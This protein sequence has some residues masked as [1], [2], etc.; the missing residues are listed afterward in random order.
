MRTDGARM[1]VL[2]LVSLP[3]LGAGNRLRVEQYVPLL[4]DLGIEMDVAPFFDDAAYAVLYA[5]GTLLFKLA[6][7]IRGLARRLDHVLRLRQYDLVLVY[8][9]SLPLGPPLIEALLGALG[10]RYVFDFDDA[11]FL[12]PVH[13]ANRSW[14][15]LR[16]PSR[17]VFSVRR[18]AAVV[19]GN[20]YLAAWARRW[21]PRVSVIPTPVDTERHVPRVRPR[22]DGP[23]VIGWVGSSTTAPY[24]HLLDEPLRMLATRCEFLVRVIG[25]EYSHPDLRVE[26]RP[27]RLVTE[28]EEV[29][30]FDIGVLP[31]PDDDWTRG[32]G[33]F[34]A[35]LYMAAEVP[36]V[37][38]RV[39]VAAE[40]VRDGE[41]GFC[42]DDLIGWAS[43]L[44]RL[45]RDPALRRD[46]GKEGR[47]RVEAHYSLR[48]QAPRLADVLR[49]A[50]HDR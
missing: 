23:I 17:V 8:R 31:Q 22:A 7:V 3:T 47:H 37:A 49:S 1:R 12:R 48:V 27:Y 24:L 42:V 19:A 44:E 33:A 36:V 16:D 15:W 14:S 32:K 25:G 50:A 41:T 45:A 20:E 28:P 11:I 46:L 2:A 21:N 35:L 5:P 6:G 30:D 43:T 26:V 9:E 39:G 4:R 29:A 34:K 13:P 10:I 38:S 40:V 18:A